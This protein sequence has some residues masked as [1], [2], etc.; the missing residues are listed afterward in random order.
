MTLF[1]VRRTVSCRV[2]TLPI[3]PIIPIFLMAYIFLYF[4]RIPI[5]S[6]IFLA[7]GDNI[8]P[9]IF[10]RNESADV[11]SILTY[12]CLFFFSNLTNA[13][14]VLLANHCTFIEKYISMKYVSEYGWS[15]PSRGSENMREY[16]C[17]IL[18][19]G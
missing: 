8:C 10:L 1:G 4:R 2:P 3:F 11:T 17:S 16:T 15:L 12:K 18:S 13:Y 7:F 6:Y 9:C 19:S 5:N 14:V